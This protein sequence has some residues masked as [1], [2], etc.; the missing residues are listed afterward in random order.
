MGVLAFVTLAQLSFSSNTLATNNETELVKVALISEAISAP[1]D[2]GI[3]W[4]GLHQKL[5]PNWHTY[6]RYAGDSGLPTKLKW[7]TFKNVE[8]GKIHWP[9]PDIIRAGPLV[10]YGYENETLLLIP[11]T[12]K[13]KGPINLKAVAEWLVCREI[14]IPQRKV[15][16]LN[17]PEGNG[18]INPVNASLFKKF[19]RLVPEEL[20]W[21]SK[22]YSIGN[23]I[24]LIITMNMDELN[25]I[26]ALHVFPGIDGLIENGEIQKFSKNKRNIIINMKAGYA[27][28]EGLKFFEGMINIK[29]SHNESLNNRS[30]RI[31]KLPLLKR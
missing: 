20:H 5:Q 21:P 30:Y 16:S 11:L 23:Q 31:K 24:T 3:I 15:L 13:K 7:E 2:L 22:V 25:S 4:V 18:Q 10:N 12:V 19:R 8:V 28:E 9:L 27:I 29:R 1:K 17:L 6:W 14:C 26:D